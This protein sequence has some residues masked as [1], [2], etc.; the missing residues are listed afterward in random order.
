METLLTISGTGVNPYS[1]RGL[2]QTLDPITAAAS[3][4]HPLR[5]V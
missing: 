2:T 5:G 1:A 4:R 3:L